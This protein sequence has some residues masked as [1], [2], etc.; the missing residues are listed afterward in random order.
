[1]RVVLPNKWFDPDIGHELYNR[2]LDIYVAAD[3]LGLNVMLNEHQA[4]PT[5]LN[6]ALPLHLATLAKI[7]KNARL[8]ALGNPVANRSEPVRVAAELATIDIVSRG[9][10]E[11]GFV[12]GSAMELTPTNTN[13][14]TQKARFW[15]AV[16]LIV[17]AWTTHDEAFCWEGEFFHH[18]SVNIWPRPYQQP[19][20]PIWA[21]TLS[22]GS[23]AEFARRGHVTATM[24][25]GHVACGEIFDAYRRTR[26]AMDMPPDRDLLAYSGFVFV[27][28]TD[29]EAYEQAT[30]LKWFFTSQEHTPS[31]FIDVPGYLPAQVRAEE[32]QRSLRDQNSSGGMAEVLRKI[33]SAP[34]QKLVDDG[35]FFV[36]SPDSVFRQMETFYER[37]GGFGNFL[38]EM[39]SGTMGFGVTVDSMQLY[40]EKV[41]PRFVEEIYDNPKHPANVGYF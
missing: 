5:C 40:A 41:L 32:L 22:A 39:Q 21:T 26:A 23:T 12:R 36:G 16:D 8:L 3:E 31:Q 33:G 1:M 24:V 20:P 2:Y 25:N 9:R 10:L 38:M 18:R 34:I 4:T 29:A 14:V 6:S 11:A 27:A 35:I 7:T 15:E 37:V 13:P 17:K 30:K 19:H 28:K